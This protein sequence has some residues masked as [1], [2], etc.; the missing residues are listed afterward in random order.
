MKNRILVQFLAIFLVT[1]LAYSAKQEKYLSPDGRYRAFVSALGGIRSGES[2]VVIKTKEG[3]TIFSKSYGSEDGEHG[4]GVVQAAWT[5]NSTFFVYSLASSGG[6]SPWHTP[7]HY[8]SVRDLK[9]RSLDDYIGAVTQPQFEVRAPDTIKAVGASWVLG[10]G[11]GEESP[12]EV[13][14]SELVARENKKCKNST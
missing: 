13:S 14:L 2:M 10:K 3:I 11:L 12:F 7:I 1:S 6:H 5:P 4:Y 8:I 9:I